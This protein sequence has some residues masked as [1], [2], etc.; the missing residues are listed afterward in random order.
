[1]ANVGFDSF[2]KRVSEALEIT[3]QLKLAEILG[4]NRSSISQAKKKGIVPDK[5]ILNL[6][7]SHGV[8][9]V[10]IESGKGQVFLN[11]LEKESIKPEYKIVRKVKAR[12]CAG[13]GSF[14]VD[15]QISDSYLFQSEWL[16]RKGRPDKMVLMDIFGNS[17]EPELK[18]GD[19]VLVDCAQ[20]DILA[21]LLYA[22][23][24]DDTIMIKRIE[25]HPGKLLLRSDNK[26]YAPIIIG[27]EDIN[28]VR[29]IGKVIWVCR[30]LW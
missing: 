8:N 19:T 12:L 29:I 27:G 25:K 9:P 21:G 20:K 7:K 28:K 18:N 23:G 13:G 26:D 14:E 22:V 11:K 24:I 30:D 17:M 6:F 4:L 15:S 5:W 10:W 16:K 3:S 1:M 2:Y